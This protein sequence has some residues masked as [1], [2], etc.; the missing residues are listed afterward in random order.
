MALFTSIEK[1]AQEAAR[2]VSAQFP[3]SSV[4]AEVKDKVVTLHGSAPDV[5]TK[6]RIMAEFSK[7]VPDAGNVVNLIRSE[8]PG[9][10]ASAPSAATTGGVAFGGSPQASAASAIPGPAPTGAS[11]ARTHTVQR[12]DTL[13]AIAKK[14]YGNA[15]AYTK[16]FE[17]NKNILKDPDHIYPGQVLTI[18]G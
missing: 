10:V 17:A 18:P 16:I 3:G 9:S 14:Y 1:D 8:H 4:T 15:N 6:G 5:V 11:A 13:S 7:L 2:K 12:G